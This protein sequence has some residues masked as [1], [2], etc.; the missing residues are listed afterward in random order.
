[1]AY[2]ETTLSTG[3]DDYQIHLN[4]LPVEMN[5]AHFVI[6]RRKCASPQ[7]Q[8]PTPEASAHKLPAVAQDEKDWSSYWVLP[9][10][11]TGFVAFDF[12]PEW[13]ADITRRIIFGCLRRSV[14]SRLKKTEYRFPEKSFIEEVSFVM[15]THPEGEEELIVQPYSLK[16]T[17]QTGFLVDFHFRLD[18]NVPFSRKIQQLSLSLDKNFRRN[19]DYYVDRSSKI[20]R[21]LEKRWP[22]FEAM[23]QPGGST[24]LRTLKEFVALP[25]ERLR[26]KVY[27]FANDKESK[28]QFTGLRDFGPL[29]PLDK[30]P[31][32]LF[33]FREPDR[34][35]ARR[36]ARS[37]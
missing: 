11:A 22:V 5:G 33:V 30:P 16:A 15:Q 18:K 36:L 8:R 37:L 17:H 26:P 1:M 7:E 4:F 32:L 23:T 12:Q 29:Q 35:A 3:K 20:R 2:P 6:Y 14:E 27:V 24:P 19:V 21:F 34:Q 28:S 10:T 25:A 13:N 31:R 9:E